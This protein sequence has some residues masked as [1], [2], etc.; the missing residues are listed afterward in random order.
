LEHYTS[1]QPPERATYAQERIYAI[2][3]GESVPHLPGLPEAI[4]STRVAPVIAP[5]EEVGEH[6]QDATNVDD[7]EMVRPRPREHRQRE[8][9]IPRTSNAICAANACEGAWR[10]CTERCPEDSEPCRTACEVEIRA[11]ARGCF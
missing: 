6:V 10:T 5:S 2:E 7:E 3:H 11:C 8:A 4:V 9:P 1:G